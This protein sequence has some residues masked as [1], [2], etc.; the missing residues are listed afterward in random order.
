MKIIGEKNSVVSTVSFEVLKSTFSEKNAGKIRQV[1]YSGLY[2]QKELAVIREY[3]TNAWDANVEAGKK[4]V[5]IEVTLPSRLEPTLSIRDFGKGLTKQQIGDIYIVFGEST[6][7]NSN[8]FVGQLGLGSK[9]GHCYGDNFIVVSR[10]NGI[11][12]TYN[13]VI[14]GETF[15]LSSVPLQANEQEGIEVCIPVKSEDIDTFRKI[16][17]DFYKFWDVVPNIKNINDSEK[18]IID[19]FKKRETF[20]KTDMWEL[21]PTDGWSSYASIKAALMGNVPYMLDYDLLKNKIPSGKTNLSSLIEFLRTNNFIL[22]F[23]IGEVEFSANRETLQ[24]TDLT[25]KSIFQKFEKIYQEIFSIVDAKI[26]NAPNLWEAMI[27]YNNVFGNQYE[28]SA[29]RNFS[30]LAGDFGNKLSWNKLPICREFGSVHEWDYELGYKSGGH[31]YYI[32]GKEYSPI[33]QSFNLGYSDTVKEIKHKR[34][35]SSGITPNSLSTVLIDDLKTGKLHKASCR[36]LILQKKYKTVHFL[37]F[38][39][40]SQKNEFYKHYNFNSVPVI[41]LSSILND[42]KKWIKDNK[43]PSSG[44]GAIK[45]IKYIDLNETHYSVKNVADKNAKDCKGFYIEQFEGQLYYKDD[46]ICSKDYWSVNTETKFFMRLKKLVNFFKLNIDKVYIINRRTVNSKWFQTPIKNG[47]WTNI[48]DHIKTHLNR[49]DLNEF[50][51]YKNYENSCISLD[52]NHL[53]EI[54][55]K[56]SKKNKHFGNFWKEI[57]IIDMSFSKMLDAIEGLKLSIENKKSSNVSYSDMLKDVYIQYPLLI[58]NITIGNT[59]KHSIDGLIEYIDLID[60][61]GENKINKKV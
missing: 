25:C 32:L 61:F 36:Y 24:Y 1:L 12:T 17:I 48:I 9:S 56:I 2:S 51:K 5:P 29:C 20:F 49:I 37:K 19:N 46:I 15:P 58:G 4:N 31:D 55:G 27:A 41:K 14:T 18:S 22:R 40:D 50:N 60:S 6:K 35:S 45:E 42:V 33:C 26:K 10:C 3:S 44:G 52:I 59:K 38:K 16:A 21:W 54:Y 47:T 30:Y 7:E 34:Y 11:K 8:D 28:L 39:N 53:N 57:S 43:T 23:D 13:C